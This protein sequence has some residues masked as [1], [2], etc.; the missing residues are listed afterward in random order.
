MYFG[1]IWRSFGNFP[2]RTVGPY[3]A[4]DIPYF[5][6]ANFGVLVGSVVSIGKSDRVEKLLL[7]VRQLLDSFK[8]R[9][10]ILTEVRNGTSWSYSRN[11]SEETTKE[12]RES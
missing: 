10:D 9:L 3:A 12:G 4:K 8:Q 7:S 1:V 2:P 6:K 5:P 11:R